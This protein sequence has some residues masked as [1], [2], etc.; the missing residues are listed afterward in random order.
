MP[1][2]SP[3][4]RL[5]SKSVLARTVVACACLAIAVGVV[6]HARGSSGHPLPAASAGSEAQSLR[7]IGHRYAECLRRHGHP[8]IADPSIASDGR[9]DFGAQDDA[10]TQASRALPGT[11]C[12][13]ELVALKDAPPLPPTPAELHRAVLF[14]QCVRRHGIP[15]WPDPRADGTYPLDA[16][17]RRAGKGDLLSLL[18]P[19]RQL[20]PAGGITISS[21]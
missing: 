8:Q 1:A 11:T 21:G 3:Q 16:R 6:V 14:S 10:V 19:C 17:L 18:A 13:R 4:R 2:M 20:S 5:G 9:I 7:L 12:L 15:D